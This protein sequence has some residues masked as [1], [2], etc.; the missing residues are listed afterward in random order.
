MADKEIATAENL[1]EAWMNSEGHRANILLKD[2]TGM[3]IGI[4]EKD[5]VVYAA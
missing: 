4:Y 2:F 1:V 5:S 3:A